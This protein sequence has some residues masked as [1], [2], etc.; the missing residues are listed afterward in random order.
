MISHKGLRHLALNVQEVAN[1]VNFYQRVFGMKIVWQPD[2][3]NT[4]L[5]SGC[6][7]LAIHRA[8]AGDRSAQSMDHLGF[9]AATPDEL[10]AGYRWAQENQVD[11]VRAI[12]RHRDGSISY[13]VRDPEGNIIQV[14]YEPSISALTIDGRAKAGN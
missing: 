5:S 11:I 1:T 13:Y 12:H 3:D 4:Y 14:L 2:E 8:P 6:D 9:I 7:N 10:E